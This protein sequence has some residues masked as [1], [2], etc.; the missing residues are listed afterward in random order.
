MQVWRWPSFQS[1]KR[2]VADHPARTFWSPTKVSKGPTLMS[3]RAARFR[4]YSGVREQQLLRRCRRRQQETS[5]SL[6]QPS[7]VEQ[8]DGEAQS[9]QQGRWRVLACCKHG[10]TSEWVLGTA[11]R[12][13]CGRVLVS[14]AAPMVFLFF[15]RIGPHLGFGLTGVLHPDNAEQ[16]NPSAHC[17][18][19]REFF[20]SGHDARQRTCGKA[21]LCLRDC[22]HEPL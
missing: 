14:T 21:Q 7:H 12:A 20:V 3:S 1:R 9:S 8:A 16:G 19:Q 2:G 11:S 17:R 15:W 4:P 6:S 18:D 10:D 13:R 5:S 22:S